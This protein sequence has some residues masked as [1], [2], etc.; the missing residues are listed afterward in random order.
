MVSMPGVVSEKEWQDERDALLLAEK[1]A[2]RQLDAIAARRTLRQSAFAIRAMLAA[3]ETK[4][5]A[6][7]F[8][9]PVV[10]E[11]RWSDTTRS[12]AA[13]VWS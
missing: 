10:H 5:E 1:E 12:A 4:E 9:V 3:A 7:A 11:Y 8:F 6:A 13:G 2:T